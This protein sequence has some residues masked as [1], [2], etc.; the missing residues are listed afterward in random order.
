MKKLLLLVIAGLSCV[1]ISGCGTSKEKIDV[2]DYIIYEETG[3]EGMG[4][5]ECTLDTDK[6]YKDLE[7]KFPEIE[8]GEEHTVEMNGDLCWWTFDEECATVEEYEKNILKSIYVPMVES[9]DYPLAVKNGDSVSMIWDCPDEKPENDALGALLGVEFEYAD[10]IKYEMKNLIVPVEVNPF[11]NIMLY[12]EVFNEELY[13]YSA[14]T[15]VEREDG[16]TEEI[17]F[18]VETEKEYYEKGDTAHVKVAE[19]DEQ[20]FGETYGVKFTQLE[21]DVVLVRENVFY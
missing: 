17:I 4:Y 14:T 15:I 11:E 18:Y 19:Y 16:K 7:E 10:K 2:N 12:A 6:L 3:C 13:V 5:V 8:Y 9:M 20:H 1:G 21:G